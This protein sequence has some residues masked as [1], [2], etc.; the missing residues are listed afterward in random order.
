M[1]IAAT[2]SSAAL[3]AP[4][5]RH[6]R[7]PTTPSTAPRH[8]LVAQY[9]NKSEAIP[10]MSH[11]SSC[12]LNAGHYYSI[13]QTLNLILFRSKFEKFLLKYRDHFIQ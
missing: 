4:L 5:G 10:N 6:R 11:R 2:V 1:R 12:I 13:R 9:A 8:R 7:A 3:P